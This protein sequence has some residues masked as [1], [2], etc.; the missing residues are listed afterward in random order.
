MDHPSSQPTL[1]S[2]LSLESKRVLPFHPEPVEG[3]RPGGV[4]S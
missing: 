3:R 4:Y 1:A 2:R